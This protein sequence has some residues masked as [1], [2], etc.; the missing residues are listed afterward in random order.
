MYTG[1]T[2]RIIASQFMDGLSFSGLPEEEASNSNMMDENQNQ[3]Q[4][5]DTNAGAPAGDDQ[6]TAAATPEENGNEE[7][8][9]NEAAA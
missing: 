5:M 2:G 6:D 1:R 9:E 7:G 3:D 8:G 4:N